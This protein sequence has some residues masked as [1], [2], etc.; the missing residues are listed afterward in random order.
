MYHTYISIYIPP[1][2]YNGL[3]PSFTLTYFRIYS[4]YAIHSFEVSQRTHCN[5]PKTNPDKKF[6]GQD[7]YIV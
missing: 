5:V 1:T 4:Q 2:G 7:K 3:A 6:V